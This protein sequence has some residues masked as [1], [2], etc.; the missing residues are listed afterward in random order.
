MPRSRWVRDLLFL[1]LVGTNDTTSNALHRFLVQVNGCCV[2]NDDAAPVDLCRVQ[3]CD[4]S[5][6]N[7][8]SA[9]GD[10]RADSLLQ[11]DWFATT[12]TARHNFQRKAK[13]KLELLWTE[14]DV[15]AHGLHIDRVHS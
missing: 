1:S 7:P 12:Q 2:T 10:G 3:T 11:H 14:N 9:P 15:R 6:V 8:A 4:D 5:H 13:K